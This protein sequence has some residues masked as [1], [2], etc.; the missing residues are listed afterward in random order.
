MD[1][2]NKKRSRYGTT[3]SLEFVDWSK[4]IDYVK[5][6]ESIFKYIAGATGNEGSSLYF[7]Y[8]HVALILKWNK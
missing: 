8:I 1:A 2:T 5:L 6:A 3:K 7:W 4:Q